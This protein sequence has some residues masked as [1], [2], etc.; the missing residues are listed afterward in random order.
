[1]QHVRDWLHEDKAEGMEDRIRAG[2]QSDMRRCS[3]PSGRN[4]TYRLKSSQAAFR[5]E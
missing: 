5:D 2:L 3:R 1:M 4:S